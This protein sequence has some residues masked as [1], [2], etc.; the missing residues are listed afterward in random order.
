LINPLLIWAGIM[1]TELLKNEKFFLAL[2]L[3]DKQIA[4]QYRGKKCPHCGAALH[5]ANYG[6]KPRGERVNLPEEYLLR[7]CLCCAA[8]GCRK[9][10]TPPSC[11]FLG[12][13][14][15]WHCFII[16]ILTQYQTN[17]Q[18]N[19]AYNLSKEF[20]IYITTITRWL[21]FY[22]IIFPASEQW[23]N[24]RGQISSCVKDNE[25]PCSLVNYFLKNKK[26]VEK[27]MIS[28]LYFLAKGTLIKQ[29]KGT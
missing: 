15:Y 2:Y 22:R 13:K 23:Q 28:Y 19:S 12:R 5:Y 9:R 1:L 8:K 11:R 4:E 16:I 21:K 14:V 20:G 27:A 10:F 7:F 17:P 29:F 24:I 6:R 25:L 18:K 3:I 26:T